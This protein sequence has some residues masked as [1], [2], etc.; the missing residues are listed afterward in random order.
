[1]TSVVTRSFAIED[2]SIRAGGD[3]RTV[4]AYA[5]VF[6][7]PTEIHDAQ[8]HYREQ[9]ARTSF[10]RT[11]QHRGLRFGVFYNHGKTLY[12][13]PSERASVP[14][15][16]PIEPP[17]ADGRGLLTVTRTTRRRRPTTC[18]RRSAT[19]T[20]PGSRSRVGSS[21]RTSRSR[22]A[23]SGRTPRVN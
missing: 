14:L 4:E 17:K 1:M 19:G 11:V 5:A 20:S 7:T 2:M 21:H 3:R 9:L 10:E 22:A 8:G 6:D 12:G 13:T 23:A 15:G 16:S 18:S